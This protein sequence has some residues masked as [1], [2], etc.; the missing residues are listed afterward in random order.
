M[1]CHTGITV[2]PSTPTTAANAQPF[3]VAEVTALRAYFPILHQQVNGKPLA[4]L[5]N[6]ASAQH[7]RSVIDA[8]A[9]YYRHD[10]SNI[11]RGVHTLSQRAT[12]A[13][14]AA[15]HKL[16]RFI[17]AR[18]EREVILTRGTTESINLIAQAWGRTF[19]QPGD[20]ILVSRLEHHANLVPWQIVAGQTGA[21]VRPIPITLDGE[22]DF[23]G[24]L[25]LLTPR[26]RVLALSH[27]SNSLGTIN[28]IEKFIAVARERGIVTV[29]DGAQA[30]PH[31]AVDVQ[32]LGC[33]FY[34]FSGHKLFG[35][36]G[37]GVLYGREALLEAMPP[38]MGGGDMILEVRF[39]GTTFNTLPHKF[40]A[41]TPNIAGFIGLGAAV[42]YVQRIGLARIAATEEA[43]L[44][45][46]T[47]QL[48]AIPGLRIIGTAPHKAAV[49][50]FVVDGIHPHDLGTILDQ[51]GVAVRTGHH[52]AMPVMEFFDVPATARASFAFYNTPAEIDQLVGALQHAR[53]LFC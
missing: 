51:E 8:E 17:N 3:S 49:I 35:P 47:A 44:H 48:L 34:A 26:T 9:D 18:S 13:F 12:D 16:Q 36:T 32:A 23:Q 43:L 50:S 28:P 53:E 15:R 38:W 52:C 4:Y 46:A 37:T 40:E 5:D 22:V 1:A 14:E 29:I 20:E 6:G 41:G 21:V 33:D 24:F 31:M 45:Y 11:H 7:P 27:V 39:E 19:L 30:V 10:H 42:D 2:T 25:D